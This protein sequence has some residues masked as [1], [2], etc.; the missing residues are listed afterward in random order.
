MTRVRP[1][2]LEGPNLFFPRPAA[3]FHIAIDELCTLPTTQMD[4]AARALGLRLTAGAPGSELRNLAVARL[5]AR[6]LRALARAA[7]Y[8]R[9]AV[10]VRPDADADHVMLVA[11]LATTGRIN[12]VAEALET[13]LEAMLT[14]PAS[15]MTVID[16][17]AG[18]IAATP[19][20]DAITPQRPAVPVVAVTGTNGKTTTVRLI[21]LMA[22][23]QGIDVATCSTDGVFHNGQIV[24]GGDYSGPAGV[25][26]ALAQPGVQLVVAETARGG[27]L[28]RGLGVA[29]N[30]VG[31]VT[32][33]S[34]DHLGLD[35]VTTLDDLAEVKSVVVRATRPGGW[36]VLNADDPRVAAMQQTTRA[37]V[38]V[39]TL[40]PE[41]P[42]GRTAL[43]MGGRVTT[44]L[45]DH[46][47]VLGLKASPVVI[48]PITDV[49][50]ALFGVST[51][52][53][54][55]ALAATSAA[56]ALGWP[57]DV[58]AAGL[59]QFRL[60]QNSPGRFNIHSVG[61]VTVILDL[62]HNEAGL[63]ALLE[64]GRAFVRPGGR[65]LVSIGTA[66]DRPQ[67]TFT[68][69]G[70][71]AALNADV[72]VTKT[73][74]YYQRGNDGSVEHAWLAE[75][76]ERA[77]KQVTATFD[78]EPSALAH[79][80]DLAEDGDVIAAMVHQHKAESADLV[81]ARGGTPDD[82]ATIRRKIVG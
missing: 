65:L 66:G 60:D 30:D 4:A 72:V 76:V 14:D 24:D 70:E 16:N 19:P 43:T 23:L 69:L 27:I 22:R 3:R 59:R 7:G 15:L 33:V 36:A 46:I 56:L 8:R 57:V 31:L 48:C 78:D 44:L 49:P 9:L 52:N 25:Q 12:A 18:V 68:A 21:A 35:G 63:A 50:M 55:N 39:F 54:D 34:A 58:V 11:P 73:A 82:P 51:A 64:A 38:W 42:I 75:G 32:N 79:L 17:W 5:L 37:R 29:S 53:V 74:E 61:G 26:L 13:L 2:V 28:R 10:R 40:D 71:M 62:A 6:A 67:A 81:R 45:D 47:V 1:H 80:L 41:S 77:G 20:G